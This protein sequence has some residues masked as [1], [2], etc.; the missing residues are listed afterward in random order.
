[1]YAQ[2][3]IPLIVLPEHSTPLSFS[4]TPSGTWLKEFPAHWPEKQ[5]LPPNQ[6]EIDEKEVAWHVATCS[7]SELRTS[8]YYWIKVI[9][10]IHFVDVTSMKNLSLD[11]GCYRLCNHSSMIH[12]IRSSGV[13]H[14]GVRR[15][16]SQ[17]SL[18]APNFS[19]QKTSSHSFDVPGWTPVPPIR[20]AYSTCHIG[21]VDDG[22]LDITCRR[23]TSRPSL[24]C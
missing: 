3:T 23:Y 6:Q 19:T 5:T 21:L 20:R 4:T 14:V 16:L 18:S 22:W 1:M 10:T 9:Q 17:T 15:Q 2:L 13:L 11:P 12:W 8:E 24:R 7:N